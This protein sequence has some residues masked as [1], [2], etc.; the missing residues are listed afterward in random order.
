[1]DAAGYVGIGLL[2]AA[3]GGIAGWALGSFLGLDGPGGAVADAGFRDRAGVRQGS[4]AAIGTARRPA[5][6]PP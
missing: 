4:A 1:V 2:G 6:A 5:G 3:L